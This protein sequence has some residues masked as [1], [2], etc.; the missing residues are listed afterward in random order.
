MP[1]YK[2]LSVPRRNRLQALAKRVFAAMQVQKVLRRTVAERH[3]GMN[4]LGLR[5]LDPQILGL[6]T[7]NMVVRSVLR[8]P[9]EP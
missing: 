6:R 1:Q 7:A 4:L 2:G 9:I 3:V 5:A 8:N